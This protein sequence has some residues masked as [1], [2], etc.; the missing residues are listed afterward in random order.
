MSDGG[1]FMSLPAEVIQQTST[2]VERF[3]EGYRRMR[4]S[5]NFGYFYF[6]VRMRLVG[7]WY[8]K[9]R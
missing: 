5:L 2:P 7:K 6:T 4:P 8:K 9:R 3:G 1:D